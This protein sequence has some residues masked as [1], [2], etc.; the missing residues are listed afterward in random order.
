MTIYRSHSFQPDD[1]IRGGVLPEAFDLTFEG[2]SEEA[3]SILARLKEQPHIEQYRKEK[4]AIKTFLTNPF[5]QYRDDLVVNW[6]LPNTLDLETERNVFSRLLKND[7]GAGGCHHHLWL[8]FYRPHLRRLTDVQLAHSI[9]PHG[10]KVGLFL[11]DNARRE[12]QAV[13]ERIKLSPNKFLDPVNALLE[14]SGW[15]LSYY[16]GYGEKTRRAS[17]SEPL[18]E[19]PEALFKARGIWIRT[20]FSKDNVLD[21]RGALVEHAVS[22]VWDLWPLYIYLTESRERV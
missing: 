13:K 3:F 8:S 15:Q 10:F 6:V 12:L 17:H 9:H 21:W 2:F 20:H 19:I 22:A 1:P 14:G 16:D 18:A 11:G 4:A 5:K 7:F